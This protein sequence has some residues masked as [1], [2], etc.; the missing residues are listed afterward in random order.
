MRKISIVFNGVHNPM[1]V[2][3]FSILTAKENGYSIQGIFLNDEP[4]NF[5]GYPFPNDLSLTEETVTSETVEEETKRLLSSNIRF[6][7]DECAGAGV[8][9]SI[10]RGA[11]FNNLIEH[12][13]TASFIALDTRV[14]FEHFDLTDVLTDAH[15]PVYLIADTAQKTAHLIFAF[16]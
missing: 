8:P 10:E 14:D 7:E 1:H 13:K 15:C 12:S 16:D 6:V 4:S 2:I 9:C 3:R 11:S 5:D